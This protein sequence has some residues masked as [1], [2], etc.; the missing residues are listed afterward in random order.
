MQIVFTNLLSHGPAALSM[1][2]STIENLCC[3]TM[4][5]SQ[6]NELLRRHVLN[7]ALGLQAHYDPKPS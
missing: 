2:V 5:F 6:D 1:T 7:D 4:T 3:L